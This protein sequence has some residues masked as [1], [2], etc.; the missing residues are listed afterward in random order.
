[1]VRCYFCDEDPCASLAGCPG[2][3]LALP[4]DEER[5]MPQDLPPPPD[6]EAR[7]I[8][9]PE[10]DELARLRDRWSEVRSSRAFKVGAIAVAGV[11]LLGLGALLGGGCSK[12]SG[13]NYDSM[14]KGEVSN[15][16]GDDKSVTEWTDNNGGLWRL[17]PVQPS[18]IEVMVDGQKAPVLRQFDVICGTHVPQPNDPRDGYMVK[19]DNQ[20]GVPDEEIILVYRKK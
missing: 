14:N 5:D 16:Q 6:Y 17:H 2:G 12:S 15:Y 7:V 11:G 3:P 9:P 13:I 8:N 1:M 4:P 18:Q 19:D 10:D 20:D